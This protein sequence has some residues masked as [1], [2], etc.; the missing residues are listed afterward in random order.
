MIC[1]AAVVKAGPLVPILDE[2]DAQI[3]RQPLRMARPIGMLMRMLKPIEAD[4]EFKSSDL[5]SLR[6][7]S[8]ETIAK[9]IH[10]FLIK[11]A[12]GETCRLN[13]LDVRT[14]TSFGFFQPCQDIDSKFG[15]YLGKVEDFLSEDDPI[16]V[17]YWFWVTQASLCKTIL[18]N[19]ESILLQINNQEKERRQ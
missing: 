15:S 18:E 5:I 9:A 4:Q 16:H 17:K 10:S 6:S 12:G 3:L 11:Q 13:K 14:G 19:R 7:T 1:F 2:M 8:F